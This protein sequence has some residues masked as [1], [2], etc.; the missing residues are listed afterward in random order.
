MAEMRDPLPSWRLAQSSIQWRMVRWSRVV[1]SCGWC[2]GNYQKLSPENEGV[3]H[4][5]KRVLLSWKAENSDRFYTLLYTIWKEVSIFSWCQ[6]TATMSALANWFWWFG[7]SGNLKPVNM[8]SS[9]KP[10]SDS[11][12]LMYS[13]SKHLNVHHKHDTIYIYI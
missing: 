9:F 7:N 12:I 2:P 3:W 1:E 10:I 6:Y 5:Q 4:P 13:H 11:I 8:G